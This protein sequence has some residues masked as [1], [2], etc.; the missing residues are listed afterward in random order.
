MQ[1]VSGQVRF[2]IFITNMCYTECI[3][4]QQKHIE[5][6]S[7]FKELWSPARQQ[8]W[9]WSRSKVKVT[10]GYPWKGLATRIMHAK[11]QC[12]IINTSEDMSQVKV[13]QNIWIIIIVIANTSVAQNTC[14]AS[15]TRAWQT[16]GMQSNPYL[17]L[18]F[19][20]TTKMTFMCH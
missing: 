11:Y 12:S 6:T 7:K 9:P 16:D 20:G 5:F 4:R 17:A 18:C 10:V 15:K 13:L 2:S 3:W 14:G 1:Q 8:I 19:A